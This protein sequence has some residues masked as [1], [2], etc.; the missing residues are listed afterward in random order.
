MSHW[1][2]MPSSLQS[3]LLERGSRGGFRDE[4]KSRQDVFTLFRS[5]IF[6]VF[7]LALASSFPFPPFFSVASPF[8]LIFETER[9]FGFSWFLRR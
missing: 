4:N 1:A 9:I 6:V 3:Q 7:L 2:S 8:T 5:R